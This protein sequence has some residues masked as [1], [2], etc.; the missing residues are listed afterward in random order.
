MQEFKEE[1]SKELN[2][3]K[4]KTKPE[5]FET[6]KNNFGDLSLPCFKLKKDPN[7][8]AKKIK[9][10]I[11]YKKNIEKLEVEGPYLNF[12]FKPS[13]LTN[14][15]KK[16]QVDKNK[17]GEQN[18]GKKKKIVLE[19][20]SPNIAKP[21]G[22][23]HLRSTMIGNSLAKVFNLLNYQVISV[24]HLGD[25][26]T[27]F[28]KLI[29]AYNKWGKEKELEKDPIKYLLKLYVKFHKELDKNKDLQE[30]AR[31]EFKKL[32]NNNKQSK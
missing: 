31:T 11:Y 19:F 20:S 15:L 4:Y 7:N 22:V 29:V 2:K 23:G 21:F 3:L 1:L 17:F 14:I 26:G 30:L 6:P 24:N 25:W 32:E 12:F 28:G 10:T 13:H 18:I 9:T 16:I 8:I 5:D 27:Q